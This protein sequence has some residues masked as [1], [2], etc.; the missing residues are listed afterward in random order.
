MFSLED[1]LA[2][3]ATRGRLM[4]QIPSGAMLSVALSEEAIQSYLHENLSLAAVNAPSSCVVSGLEPAIDQLQEKLESARVSCRRLHTSHAF[5][6][7][8]IEPVIE[9]FTQSLGKVKLN[10]PQIPFL[11]NVTGTWIT[12]AQATDSN[13]WASHLR[14][15]VCFN[16]GVIELLKQ[17]EQILLEVGPG[18]TL[19]SLV[20]QQPTKEVLALTS[21]RHPQEQ[22]SDVAFLLNTLGKLWLVG[23]QIDWTSFYI[24]EQRHRLPLPTYPFERQRYWIDASPE[25]AFTESQQTLHKN[26]NIADWFY[27]PRWKESTPI[28]LFQKEKLTEQKSCWL[29]FIDTYGIG[30]EIAERLTQQNQDVIL[31]KIADKFAKLND[32]TYGINPQQRDDY[33]LLIQKLQEQNWIPQRIA[34]F[35]SVTPNDILSSQKIDEQTQHQFFEDCQYL[36]F[37]SLLFL[38]QALGQQDI[39][40]SLKLTV[41][42]SNLY[43]IAGKEKLCPHKATVLGP[44]KVIP[45]EYPNINCCTIDI[46][47]P[48]S[49]TPSIQNIL[50]CLITEFTAKQT[51]NIVAYRGFHRWIQTFEAVHLEQSGC[52]NIKLQTKGVYLIAGGLGGIGLAL[53]EYLAKTVQAKLVLVGRKSIPEKDNWQEWLET[54]DKKD[55]ISCIIRK[56]QVL[57][58]LGAEVFVVS[59]DVTNYKQVKTVIDIS[60]EKFGQINGVIH[61][62]GIASGGVIQL[63]TEDMANNVLAP[64]VRGTI[65]IKESLKNINLDFFVLC[66]SQSSILGEFGQVDYCAANAFLDAYAHLNTYKLNQFTVSINWDAWQEV[67]MAVETTV[68]DELKQSRE[69][70]LKKGIIPQEGAD[71]FHRILSSGLPQVVVSTRDFPSIW[72][73]NLFFKSSEEELAFLEERLASTRISKPT[74]PRPNLK[75]NYVPA[76]NEIE[77]IIVQIWQEL[78]GIEKVGIH[79]NFFDLGGNSLISIQLVSQLQKK[80]NIQIPV[81]S[82]YKRPTVSSLAE[83][84]SSSEDEKNIGEASNS[85]GEKRREKKKQ[86]QRIVNK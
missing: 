24:N 58:A 7:Q 5:H 80:L 75:S 51:N 33:D 13:Y 47:I 85:R 78:L 26:P 57:E 77:Q 39:S 20:K 16:Q 36:G 17:P 29:V 79:D 64:K 40:D 44:C 45:K 66:S 73:Q 3:V 23:V 4:Q 25:S 9:T 1:A 37:W 19:S 14:Q 76:R 82:L 54:H 15:P 50:D 83:I 72:K 48:S 35:W 70:S 53:A 61:A 56:L 68:P 43:D 86:R 2:L 10:P 52:D 6:S 67:G 22:Q 42:T 32:R 21:I 34:H 31:V 11:S 62:A 63:K 38:A 55:K 28:E 60:I 71:S 18:R 81:V 8:M 41:V 12:A 74:H 30:A 49:K 69:E 65:V 84:L 46:V 27:V 59:T